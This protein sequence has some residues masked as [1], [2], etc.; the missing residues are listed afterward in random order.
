MKRI[1]MLAVA[2]ALAPAAH[3][4]DWPSRPVKFVCAFAP[5]GAN[6][7]V[8]R[9]LAQGVGERLRTQVVVENRPGAAGR[10]ATTY[11][12]K[13]KPDGY[14]FLMGAPGLLVLNHFLY[15]DVDYKV[16]DFAGV[17]LT[18]ILPY[19][20]VANPKLGASSVQDLVAA[21]KQKPGALN[22]GSTGS[23][24]TLV[25]QLFKERTGTQFQNVLYK[26]TAPAIQELMQGELHFMFDLIAGNL[27]A[28]KAGSIRALAVSA[29]KRSS[30]LPELP[31]MEEAG[32]AG[33]APTNWMGIVAPAAT[34][35]PIV[36][37]L[38]R[39][40]GAL[41][42]EPAFRQRLTQIGADPVGGAPA[43]YDAFIRK[44]YATWEAMARNAGLQ[45][46]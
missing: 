31:T 16:A 37:R 30:S 23:G 18:G 28:I 15:K 5:G 38:G 45:K 1:L 14:T 20:L 25:Q 2:A 41:T 24:P 42:A 27:A 21:L 29:P 22:H 34:P 33:F 8:T 44:E 26:G 39:E 4:D 43:E 46:E 3:A 19:V 6:D 17:S 11:V 7:I 40:L 13:E 10:I 9:L 32:I 35:R 36:E 12:A